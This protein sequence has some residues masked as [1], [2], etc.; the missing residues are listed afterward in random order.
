MEI[1]GGRK[2][3]LLT[4]ANHAQKRIKAGK[5]KKIKKLKSSQPES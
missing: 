2:D 4:V 5:L 1:F 3:H